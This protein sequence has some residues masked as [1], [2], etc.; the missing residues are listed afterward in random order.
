[1]RLSSFY[2]FTL[3]TALTVT[4][5][6][7]QLRIGTGM[8]QG[9]YEQYCANCHGQQMEGGL[10]G[11]LID[12]NWKHGSSDE[13]IAAVIRNGW[14][15]LGM[16]AYGDTLNEEQIRAL[17]ILIREQNELADKEELL[18]AT[19]PREGVFQ[20]QEHPFR[21]E[22][23]AEGQG[24]LW[25]MDALP[26]GRFILTEKSG[27]LWILN[28]NTWEGPIQGIPEV[29]DRGQGGLLEVA[30]HPDYESN[31]WIYLG[32]SEKIAGGGLFSGGGGSMTTLVRGKIRGNQW[33]EEETLFRVTPEYAIQSAHHFG[34]RI[35]F[36][37]GYLFFSIGDR[38]RQNMAQ[39][40]SNP[41]GKIHRIHEDGRIPEDNPF[42]DQK[43]AYPTIWCY[44]NR[45]PQGLALHPETGEL[46][47]TEHGPRGGDEVNLIERGVNYGW[48]EITHGMNYSGTP[49]TEKTAMPGMA[50]PVLHWTPSIAVCG[51]DFYTG[52]QF[53]H[54]KNNLFVGGL[55]SEELHRLVIQEGNI[56][57]DEILFK[58][59]G[60]VRDVFNGPDGHLY[61]LLE[62][63]S[64]RVG[65]VYR[66]IPAESS[67][68]RTAAR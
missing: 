68:Q 66:L 22:K 29:V 61:V 40:L 65:S 30:V 36:Q 48:P 10:G 64:P 33:V 57:M 18:Q 42:V 39:D 7:A 34:T 9:L 46:W 37:E 44:G 25:G 28:G 60:R 1:M 55:A 53:P 8:A 63:G 38:G 15:E 24:I 50:Q 41:T 14:P 54:W 67:P 47:E 32:F 27:K 19:T 31:G 21:L 49:I 17:V 35:V 56:V 3:L 51:I 45:N 11:S 16:E 58:N 59:Q 13:A 4:P 5:L 43:G 12:G 6:F 52:D 62:S 26:D 23:I 2:L 20:S